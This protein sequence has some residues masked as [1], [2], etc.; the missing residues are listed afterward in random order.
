MKLLWLVYLM[1]LWMFG[2]SVW[3]FIRFVFVVVFVEE[4][5]MG[6]FVKV[7]MV[8]IMRISVIM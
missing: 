4:S 3:I 6:L 2:I 8:I 7:G 5:V 1:F